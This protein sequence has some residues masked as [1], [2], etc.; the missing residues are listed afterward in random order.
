MDDMNK[1]WPSGSLGLDRALG[2]G[3]WP[4]GRI[5][6]IHGPESSGKTTLALHAIAQC[7]KAGGISA[8][9]DAEHALDRAY[10]EKVGVKVVDLLI[11]QPGC[12]SEALDVAER[13]VR[14][15]GRTA[16]TGLEL[17]VV[18]LGGFS[19]PADP[20]AMHAGLEAR[21]MSQALRRL[22]PLVHRHGTTLIFLSPTSGRPALTL[23]SPET[24][25]GGRALR[26]YASVRVELARRPS[27]SEASPHVRVKVVKN[28]LAAPHRETELDIVF[29]RG[30]DREAE[31]LDLG[32]ELG[33][34]AKKG[35]WLSFGETRL[36]QGR[37]NAADFLRQS[38]DVAA[39]LEAA[40]R[41]V[42]LPE[43]WSA[44]PRE[45]SPC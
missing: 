24:T 12:L 20:F 42:P 34:C 17:V 10:A 2:I 37:P 1:T 13:L 31:L 9:I 4:A 18:D 30:I 39:A 21:L 3:G 44:S 38:S 23:G 19:P 11:S 5:V 28:K 6:E 36:G 14:N 8:F 40:I 27:Q 15:G 29:G 7:Q 25:T 41:A 45:V 16:D 33:L 22:T 32:L 43:P 26:F 35:A